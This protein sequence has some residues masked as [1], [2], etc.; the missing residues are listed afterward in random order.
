MVSE[1]IGDENENRI[2]GQVRD[3]EMHGR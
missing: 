2:V 3:G 1:S